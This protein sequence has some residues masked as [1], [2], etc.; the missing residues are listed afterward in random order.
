MNAAIYFNVSTNIKDVIQHAIFSQ[1]QE[2]S[3][4]LWDPIQQSLE[5]VRY[6]K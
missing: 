1:G 6:F 3:C 4:L 2:I 5:N